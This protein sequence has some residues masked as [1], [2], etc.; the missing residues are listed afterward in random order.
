MHTM[1]N[2]IQQHVK[3]HA[4]NEALKLKRQRTPQRLG[5]LVVRINGSPWINLTWAMD[6]H[7]ENIE[8]YENMMGKFQK[9]ENIKFKRNN[10]NI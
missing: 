1:T 2:Y 5:S 4:Y 8:V 6:V 7:V 3:F 10:G 9:Y